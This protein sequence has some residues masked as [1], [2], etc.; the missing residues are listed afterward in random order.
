MSV[1]I[2]GVTLTSAAAPGSVQLIQNGTAIGAANPLSTVPGVIAANLNGSGTAAA[3][4]AGSAFVSIA[5]VPT[6]WYTIR[7]WY[8]ITGAVEAA[9]KN[10]RLSMTTGGT[11]SDYPSGAGTAAF[12]WFVVD[13]VLVSNNLDTVK[14]TAV[15]AATAATVYTGQL[16]MYRLA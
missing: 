2:G 12:Y 7:G 3:P 14:L 6:G 9:A 4:G 11:I 13:A 5:S 10:V 15:A 1:S 16:T 8:T